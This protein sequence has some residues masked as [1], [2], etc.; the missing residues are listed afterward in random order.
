MSQAVI[1]PTPEEPVPGVLLE[2]RLR[3][4]RGTALYRVAVGKATVEDAM[5]AA[6]ELVIYFGLGL[7]ES[8]AKEA[9]WACAVS[10][11]P[12]C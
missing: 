12:S 4:A 9:E 6:L 7:G 8:I 3:S 2:V 10:G 11:A 1:S 5:G